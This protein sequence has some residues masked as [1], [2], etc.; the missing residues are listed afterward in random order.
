M[1]ISKKIR[2][3]HHLCCYH[4]PSV[5]IIPQLK[6]SDSFLMGFLASTLV[7]VQAM[8]NTAARM[9]LFTHVGLFLSSSQKQPLSSHLTH[10]KIKGLILSQD[11][12]IITPLSL[13]RIPTT[14]TLHHSKFASC[15]SAPFS[16]HTGLQVI[17]LIM[18]QTVLPQAFDI[19]C[20]L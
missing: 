19:C 12:Y 20:P 9:I 5:H 18:S 7:H 11:P 3:F 8:P 2:H 15:N 1:D 13:F 16:C 6:Y 17:P 14:T 10:N 4:P